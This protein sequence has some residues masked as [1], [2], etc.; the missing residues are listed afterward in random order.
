MIAWKN[1]FAPKGYASAAMVQTWV[2][3]KAKILAGEGKR[4]VGDGSKQLAIV[5]VW[6]EKRETGPLK[7]GRGRPGV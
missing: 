4:G 7:R 5:K 6:V 2:G 1:S 3:K